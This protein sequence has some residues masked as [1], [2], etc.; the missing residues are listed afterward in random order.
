MRDANLRAE[1]IKLLEEIIG[2]MILEIGLGTILFCLVVLKSGN[3][4]PPAC[5]YF[6]TL[7]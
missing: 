4:R 1:T 7:S 2:V 6:S 5:Y 3:L